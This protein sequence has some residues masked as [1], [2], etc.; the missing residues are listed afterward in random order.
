MIGTTCYP[1]YCLKCDHSHREKDMMVGGTLDGGPEKAY[2]CRKSMDMEYY[3]FNNKK[4]PEY[5]NQDEEDEWN[6]YYRN[7]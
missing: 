1:L 3:D 5:Y 4:C 6:I 2:S 7:F